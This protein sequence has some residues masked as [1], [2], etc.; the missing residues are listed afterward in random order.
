MADDRGGRLADFANFPVFLAEL[1]AALGSR[2]GISLT[3]P[4]SY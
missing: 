4:S 1:C 3:L 2:Y